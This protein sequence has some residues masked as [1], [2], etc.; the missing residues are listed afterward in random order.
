MPTVYKKISL[1][2]L[3]QQR[4]LLSA[5]QMAAVAQEEPQTQSALH[6][7]L[8]KNGLLS[9]EQLAE[10]LAEQYGLPFDTLEDYRVEFDSYPEILSEWMTRHAF[11]PLRMQDGCLTIAIAAPHDVPT[12]DQLERL[13]G[14]EPL[15]VVAPRS[16]ILKAI[17]ESQNSGQ[18]V[19]RVNYDVRPVLVQENE[20]GEEI[21]SSDKI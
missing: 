21:L 17:E 12:L 20:Q 18:M 3:L 1:L 10:L 14:K 8:L 7:T 5:S 19:A 11:V 6:T 9:E 15:L 16:A 4:S 13:L 2:D